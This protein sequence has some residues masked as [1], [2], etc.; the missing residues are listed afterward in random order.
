[1]VPIVDFRSV[2]PQHCG[3]SEK[4]LA[5]AWPAGPLRGPMR[6]LIWAALTPGPSKPSPM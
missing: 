4:D 5:K 6:M 1:M 2:A 3:H